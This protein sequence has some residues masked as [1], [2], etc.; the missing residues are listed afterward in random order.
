MLKTVA[1][2]RTRIVIPIWLAVFSSNFITQATVKTIAAQAKIALST[3]IYLK[4]TTKVTCLKRRRLPFPL[5]HPLLLR[6]STVD[7]LKV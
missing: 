5:N 1:K 6:W 4:R 3:E 2:V 7:K